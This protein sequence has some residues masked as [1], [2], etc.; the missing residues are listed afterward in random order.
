MGIIRINDLKLRTIIG[1]NDWERE[2]PQDIVL[3]IE[4]EFDE[5]RAIQ[6]DNLADTVDY[7]ALEQKIVKLVTAARFQLVEKLAA[8]VL[9]LV[10]TEEKVT[11][12]KVILG[13]PKA[14]RFAQSV[15]VELEKR[16]SL[17]R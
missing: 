1:T 4:F 14:L 2:N 13:K 11:A 5:A 9:N 3:N 7:N 8:E 15:S 12:A 10:L 17:V 6:S 16:K